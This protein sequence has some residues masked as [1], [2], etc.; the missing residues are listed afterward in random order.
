MQRVLQV[1][2]LAV[3]S[4]FG[5]V[6][7]LGMMPWLMRTYCLVPLQTCSFRVKDVQIVFELAMGLVLIQGVVLFWF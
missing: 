5:F 7:S 4:F 1:F 2:C 3:C 6:D